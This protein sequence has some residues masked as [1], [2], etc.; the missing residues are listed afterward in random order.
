MTPAQLPSAESIQLLDV[1]LSDDF[2]AA[3]LIHAKNNCV[4]EVVFVERLSESAPDPA[5]TTVVYG[6]NGESREAEAAREKLRRLG[7]QDIH[8][9]E[10]GF[11]AAQAAGLKVVQGEPLAD[12]PAIAD[13]THNIDLSESRLE[14]LGR[15][16]MNKHWGT[17]GIESGHL[18]YKDGIL[19]GGTFVIDLTR[20]ECT[21]LAG[22]DMHNY[23][24]THLHNDDFFDVENH[25]KSTFVVTQVAPGPE[26][27]PGSP[28]LEITGNLTLR[29]QTHPISFLAATGITPEG[30]AAAQASFAIDR[31]RWGILYGSGKFFHR[32]AGH[33]VNDELEF[34][35]RVITQ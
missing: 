7:Y 17:V 4:F 9:L 27:T 14:W 16:L 18:D 21:D 29:G 28:N 34:Q 3:H 31:T 12:V 1:R 10:G 8:I 23:L 15:N 32:L 24:I 19:V 26:H 25:P 33:V 2:E 22:T 11:E 35:L 20:I 6:A 5:K 30:K 13:G